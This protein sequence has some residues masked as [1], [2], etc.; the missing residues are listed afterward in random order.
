MEDNNPSVEE[1]LKSL[2]KTVEKRANAQQNAS[3]I[4]QLTNPVEPKDDDQIINFLNKIIESVVL[5]VLMENKLF[6]E[7]A[8]ANFFLNEDGK[9]VFSNA[10]YDYLQSRK[11]FDSILKEMIEK[12]LSNF[13]K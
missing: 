3:G 12:K 5:R 11:D 10:C 7:K 13:L 6:M 9:K 4:L 2:R 8:I 1:L